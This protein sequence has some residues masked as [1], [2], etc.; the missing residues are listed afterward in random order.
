MSSGE[1]SS[2]KV[3]VPAKKS[4]FLNVNIG[5]LGHVDSGKTSLVKALSTSLSTAALD[6]N[7]QSQA[8]GITIDLGFSAFQLP[9][10]DHLREEVGDK[11]DS[12]QFTLVDCPGHASLIRT[13]IG[14]A[15]IID[16]MILV[17]DANK[18]IQTQ[19]A[20]CIIIGEMTTEKLII[21]VNKIDLLPAEGREAHLEK[22]TRRLRRAF[23]TTKFHDAP[24]VTTAAAVGGEKVASIGAY[25]NSQ[26]STSTS[27]YT[28]AVSL[29][30]YGVDNLISLIKSSVS[31]PVRHTDAPFYYAVDHCFAIKGHGTVLTGTVLSGS[32]TPGTVLEFPELQLQRKV[33][34]MQMFHKTVKYVQQGDR[35]GMCVTNL[36][37]TLI[38]RGIAA[39]PN[40]VP[41]LSTMVCLVKKIRFFKQSC[42]SGTKF[43]ITVGHTTVIAKVTFFG[44]VELARKLAGKSTGNAATKAVT[45][46]PSETKGSSETASAAKAS[47]SK[48]G[49]N[50]GDGKVDKNVDIAAAAG[51]NTLSALSYSNNFPA[52]VGFDFGDDFVY[53]DEMVSAAGENKY[54]YG[55]EPVQWA[56]L[57]LQT[58]V[59]CPLGSLVIGSRLDMDSS[60]SSGR[61]KSKHYTAN[62]SVEELDSHVPMPEPT[63]SAS[64]P[65][66]TDTSPVDIME[67]STEADGGCSTGSCSSCL[68]VTPAL[69]PAAIVAAA[70]ASSALSAPATVSVA[71]SNLSAITVGTS[72]K[73]AV[74]QCRLA[75]YGPIKTFVAKGATNAAT[76]SVH[77]S[78]ASS[79]PH[80][81]SLS[82]IRIYNWK[83]KEGQV[84]KLVDEVVGPTGV[85]TVSEL[86]GS[87]LNSKGG[88]LTPFI[89]MYVQVVLNDVDAGG[90]GD[91]DGT[92]ADASSSAHPSDKPPRTALGIIYGLVGNTA[93]FKVRLMNPYVAHN[94][95]SVAGFS[96]IAPFRVAGV[97]VGSKIILKFK[98]YHFDVTKAMRQDPPVPLPRPVGYVE[99]T[100]DKPSG[101][102]SAAT[103]LAAVSAP[104]EVRVRSES[105]EEAKPIPTIDGVTTPSTATETVTE[106]A[107][108]ADKSSSVSTSSAFIPQV[109][110]VSINQST[111]FKVTLPP[112]VPVLPAAITAVMKRPAAGDKRAVPMRTAS[113]PR[114]TIAPTATASSSS[115]HNWNSSRAV[116]G[117]NKAAAAGSTSTQSQ[118]KVPSK[119][120]QSATAVSALSPPVQHLAVPNMAWS[121]IVASKKDTPTSAAVTVEVPRSN[122]DEPDR[123]TKRAVAAPEVRLKSNST[124]TDMY[125]MLGRSYAT[126]SGY[127]RGVVGVGGRGTSKSAPRARPSLGSGLS[128][129]GSS[130]DTDARSFAAALSSLNAAS[131]LPSASPSAASRRDAS[132][133]LYGRGVRFSAANDVETVGGRSGGSGS[134]SNS[135]SN[136]GVVD[137]SARTRTSILRSVSSPSYP[138]ALSQPPPPPPA[139]AATSAKNN[140]SNAVAVLPPFP[141]GS[142]VR[143]GII[144]SIKSSAGSSAAD[145]SPLSAS[146]ASATP[147][148]AVRYDM[149]IVSQAFRME[150]NIKLYIGAPVRGPNGEPGE[151]VGP[152]AKM[153]KCKVRFPG[154]I[155]PSLCSQS[156]DILI[157]IA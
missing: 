124:L 50:K 34:S 67:G 149:V 7:P 125:R 88:N 46:M 138:S 144:D 69:P 110:A 137:G 100:T 143:T 154:G 15:Q 147:A 95:S 39:A 107:P 60:G 99:P 83:E 98:K 89:G 126:D 103:T 40:S 92:P 87:K 101:G 78:V 70:A 61:S 64:E 116:V 96:S 22:V 114:A 129:T 68:D 113:A 119:P 31:I 47:A 51:Q 157:D 102:I 3:D 71:T 111:K 141:A 139:A 85:T 134:A 152:Y 14:G 11:Y 16:M 77:S 131:G 117:A 5:I 73:Q 133:S 112:S 27:H 37:P 25:L 49:N 145:P 10:P 80:G 62:M 33:K 105:S 35:V 130:R 128:G 53:Q 135:S 108:A 26:S 19:T 2:S 122:S 90:D 65:V 55:K 42:P 118:L 150:D 20:E 29:A 36:D 79:V 58:P 86:I 38:E 24:I 151:L 57:E 32:I 104:A 44:A 156:V 9:I 121:K 82:D 74:K 66:V 21:V 155:S 48:G 41:L 23:S 146:G 30:N 136:L 153:G 45:A 43:H 91:V 106:T 4:K 8:R 109:K 13:I 84:S 28:G 52:G 94:L 72:S 76:S 75:F 115:L 120:A 140:T 6:K 148:A 142:K 81:T 97:S 12:I 1:K 17:V 123:E 54:L 59:Y 93:R 63:E 56:L 18:G 132:S 127:A